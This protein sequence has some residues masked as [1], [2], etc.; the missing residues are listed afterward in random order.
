MAPLP[1][2]DF[3]EASQEIFEA[4][5]L[6]AVYS[7]IATINGEQWL[8]GG[9]PTLDFSVSEDNETQRLMMRAA[10]QMYAALAEK[11]SALDA[12]TDALY[13]L[14][15]S[16]TYYC[17]R[18]E[19][20]VESRPLSPASI[21]SAL[22]IAL[23]DVRAMGPLVELLQRLPDNLQLFPSILKPAID[24][25]FSFFPGF[26]MNQLAF[27]VVDGFAAGVSKVEPK[28]DWTA[29]LKVSTAFRALYMGV[30][31]M[32][33]INT[34]IQT[35]DL[36][37]WATP[38]NV[39]DKTKIVLANDI[40]VVE[41]SVIQQAGVLSPSVYRAQHDGFDKFLEFVTYKCKQSAVYTFSNYSSHIKG[42]GSGQ[43]E[44]R[45]TLHTSVSRNAGI[46]EGYIGNIAG[47]F[48]EGGV[49]LELEMVHGI[50]QPDFEFEN[51]NENESESESEKD[52][53]D[54]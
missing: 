54:Q 38:Q 22:S 46:V 10:N 44:A 26:I 41:I 17:K 7:G 1:P 18:E 45:Y 25:T 11:Q 16:I 40:K 13:L 4:T 53:S 43:F 30:D 37:V 49:L 6:V 8:E 35:N 20:R 19:L 36:S 39:T 50:T 14:C 42:N 2:T 9:A 52:G 51:E 5:L 32:R 33:L 21:V 28:L 24:A 48:G 23:K 12:A 15:R 47:E 34:S 31:M 3:A 27:N 29:P